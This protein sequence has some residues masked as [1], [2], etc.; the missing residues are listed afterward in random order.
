MLGFKTNAL[1]TLNVSQS[2]SRDLTLN[3]KKLNPKSHIVSC[4][5]LVSSKKKHAPFEPNQY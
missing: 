4:K 5:T 2:S 3:A 1:I